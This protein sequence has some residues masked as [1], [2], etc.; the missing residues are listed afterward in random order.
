MFWAKR[1]NQQT[2]TDSSWAVSYGDLATLLLAVFVMIAAMSDLDGG[3][4]FVRMSNGV[5]KAF[6]LGVMPLPNR[7]PSL[8]S[9][10]TLLDRLKQ[11]GFAQRTK[12]QLIGP[13]DEALAACDVLLS[14]DA[15]TLQIAGTQSFTRHSAAL[16]PTAVKALQRIAGYLAESTGPVE[17]RGHAGDGRLPLGAP[18]RDNLDLSY[19]RARAVVD[20]LVERGVSRDRIFVTASDSAAQSA[21][22]TNTPSSRPSAELASDSM[23]DVGRCIEI[24]VHASPEAAHAS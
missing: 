4:R 18:F 20:V 7:G 14:G 5:R 1:L 6:G 17:I 8:R 19:A 2:E 13:D 24:I 21:A 10:P 12:V 11:A 23:P 15:L 22:E 16:Q 9:A 3:E